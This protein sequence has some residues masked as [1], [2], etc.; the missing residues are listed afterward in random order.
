MYYDYDGKQITPEQ[1]LHLQQTSN[2]VIDDSVVGRHVDV[3]T[4]WHGVD[5]MHG[6]C[7]R[8]QI[9]VTEVYGGALNGARFPSAT[10]CLALDRH[11]GVVVSLNRQLDRTWFRRAWSAVMILA[12]AAALLATLA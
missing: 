10:Y 11:R 8:P 4:K 7:E 2:K 9:F 6:M 1:W 12:M 3:I 5:L